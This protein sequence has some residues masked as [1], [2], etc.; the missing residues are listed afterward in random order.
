MEL[1]C[2]KLAEVTGVKFWSAVCVGG[3]PLQVFCST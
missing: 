2:F 3:Y 1:A